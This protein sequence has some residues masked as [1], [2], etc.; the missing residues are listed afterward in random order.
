VD[1]YKEKRKV[2]GQINFFLKLQNQVNVLMEFNDS[3]D[4]KSAHVCHLKR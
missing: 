1:Y 2:I 4:S 3:E